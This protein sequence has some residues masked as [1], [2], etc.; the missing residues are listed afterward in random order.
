MIVYL[1]EDLAVVL[2]E[3]FQRMLLNENRLGW[4]NS[5][6]IMFRHCG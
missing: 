1:P 2:E 6:R 4:N 5:T 3:L